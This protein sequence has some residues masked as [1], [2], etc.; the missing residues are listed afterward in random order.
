MNGPYD[1]R[2]NDQMWK[3][4]I[5]LLFLLNVSMPSCAHDVESS[6][7]KEYGSDNLFPVHYGDEWGF[8]SADGDLLFK[9]R[10]YSIRS[11]FEGLAIYAVSKNG[12]IKYGYINTKGDVVI[13]PKYDNAGDFA[14][15]LAPVLSNRKWGFINTKGEYVIKAAYQGA[16]PFSEGLACV[17]IWRTIGRAAIPPGEGRT[18]EDAPLRYF[19]YL[20]Y[21]SYLEMESIAEFPDGKYGYIDRNGIM[22]VEPH[23]WDYA[24]A[25]HDGCAVVRKLD[26]G[27]TFINSKGEMIAGRWFESCDSFSEGMA[28]VSINRK[29]GYINTKGELIIPPKFNFVGSFSEGIA[30]VEVDY[31]KWGAIN[32]KGLFVIKPIYD[33]LDNFSDGLAIAELHGKRIFIDHTGKQVKTTSLPV[34]WYGFRDGLAIVGLKGKRVYINKKGKIIAP[35]E[36]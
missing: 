1:E 9:I 29:K 4:L 34:Q 12:E 31:E 20:K 7:L 13:E 5:I 15:G 16:G 3:L 28:A 11:F 35:Y 21:L 32:K 10:C 2:I 33:D 36:K 23:T 18:N 19:R 17:H 26:Q 6:P 14:E 25:F 27:W 8:I 24:E 22:V 30:P